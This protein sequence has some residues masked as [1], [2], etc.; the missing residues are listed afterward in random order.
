MSSANSV[1]TPM[2]EPSWPTLLQAGR[3]LATIA[4]NAGAAFALRRAARQAQRELVALDDRMLADMG[5]VRAGFTAFTEALAETRA[6]AAS[7][8]FP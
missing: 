4:A 1:R 5:L 7:A 3:Y 8:Q 2:S 6:A